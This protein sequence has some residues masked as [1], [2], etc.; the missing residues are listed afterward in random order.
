MPEASYTVSTI[1]NV[2]DEAGAGYVAGALTFGGGECEVPPAGY[3]NVDANGAITDV[4]ITS[5]E[6]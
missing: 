5:K 4:V 3:N 6:S 2:D 1:V